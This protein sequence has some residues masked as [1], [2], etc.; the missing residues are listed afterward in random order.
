MENIAIDLKPYEGL[1]LVLGQGCGW[2][3]QIAIDLKPYEGLKL[4]NDAYYTPAADCNRFK[5]LWGIETWK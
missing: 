2:T 3:L 5:T 1:K 4:K